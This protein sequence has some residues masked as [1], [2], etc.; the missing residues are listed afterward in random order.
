MD[1]FRH[2]CPSLRFFGDSKRGCSC[3]NDEIFSEWAP[4]EKVALEVAT[5]AA[6]PIPN[7]L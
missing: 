6:L 4:S 2:F 7:Y 5:G 3:Q 1:I